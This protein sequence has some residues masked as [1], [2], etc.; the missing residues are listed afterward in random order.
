MPSPVRNGGLSPHDVVH[1]KV[2]IPRRTTITFGDVPDGM[3]MELDGDGEKGRKR[4]V[5][6]AAPGGGSMGERAGMAGE[7]A[8]G[9]DV[10]VGEARGVED[11]MGGGTRLGLGDDEGGGKAREGEKA[12]DVALSEGQVVHRSAEV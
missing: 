4:G 8:F 1:E 11:S 10:D 3:A 2:A 5:T 12:E 9:N 7:K 6:I